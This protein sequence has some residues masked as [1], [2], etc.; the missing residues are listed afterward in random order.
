[1]QNHLKFKTNL[2]E[3]KIGFEFYIFALHFTLTGK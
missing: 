1:M 2:K 3:A